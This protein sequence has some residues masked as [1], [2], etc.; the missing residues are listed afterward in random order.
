MGS[1]IIGMVGVLTSAAFIYYCIDFKKEE[2][3]EACHIFDRKAEA[4]IVV[5]QEETLPV[6]KMPHTDDIKEAK[7]IVDNNETEIEEID[8]AQNIVKSDPAFGVMFGKYINIVGIFAPEAKNKILIHFIDD[9][10]VDRMC[11]N[12]IRYS[13]DIKEVLWQENMVAL[14]QMFHE[15]HIQKG[16]LYINSNVLHIEGEIESE[17][18]KKRLEKLI[19]QLKADGVFVEDETINM[20]TKVEGVAFETNADNEIDSIKN[21]EQNISKND[22]VKE[23]EKTVEDEKIVTS[24]TVVNEQT[25]ESQEE[26]EPQEEVTVG[27]NQVHK[28]KIEQSEMNTT[29]LASPEKVELKSNEKKEDL[30]SILTHDPIKFDS[31][32]KVIKEESRKTLDKIAE[33]LKKDSI[34]KIEVLGYANAGNSTLLN[35]IVSQKK[36]DI[37]KNYLY[38]KGLRNIVSKGMGAQKKSLEI[39]INVK[40]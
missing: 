4:Q 40:K 29:M 30:S 21:A 28:T 15:E 12:D 20:I 14:I 25:V 24:Q 19:A 23:E 17:T 3:A 36:A 39:E 26:V 6:K 2:I 11:K 34:Q 22:I 33:M 16:S 9:L 18:Q 35:M 7:I 32:V 27:E 31:R 8:T 13:D 38:Q 37:V 10:C 1:K 5:S